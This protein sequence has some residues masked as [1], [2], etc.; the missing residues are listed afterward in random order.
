MTE[1][2]GLIEGQ[3]KVKARFLRAL[4]AVSGDAENEAGTR[5]DTETGR[6]EKTE[7]EQE[8]DMLYEIGE[9]LQEPLDFNDWK[10]VRQF[11]GERK[12]QYPGLARFSGKISEGWSRNVF[13]VG[14]G[15]EPR[16]D[17]GAFSQEQAG[18]LEQREDSENNGRLFLYHAES[19]EDILMLMDYLWNEMISDRK[20]S[21][22]SWIFIEAVDG[23]LKNKFCARYL[24]KYLQQCSA[25]RTVVTVAVQDAVGLAGNVEQ[26]VA[27][28]ELVGG[29]GYVKLLNLG[30]M[31]RKKLAEVLNLPNALIPYVT[32]VEPSKGLILTSASN[33][34]FDDNFLGREDPFVELFL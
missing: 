7:D 22:G 23:L 4:L 1:G 5:K 16:A 8:K 24:M 19:T 25:F 18:T 15:Q 6:G 17:A 26:S 3:E 14:T 11:L 20:E 10:A 27:L 33:V 2:Y 28:E 34:P 30:P 32:N 9:F 13:P 12:G 29:C 31:E 21:R